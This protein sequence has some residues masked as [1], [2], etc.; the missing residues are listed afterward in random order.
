MR[1]QDAGRSTSKRGEEDPDLATK[2][3]PSPSSPSSF[4]YV[5]NSLHSCS[6]ERGPQ[7]TRE[8]DMR[9]QH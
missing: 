7:R 1:R 5:G 3:L 8:V 2:S 4:G 6:E 9:H